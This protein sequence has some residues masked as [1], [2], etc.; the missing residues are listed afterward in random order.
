MNKNPEVFVA[1][2]DEQ[3]CVSA[4]THLSLFDNGGHKFLVTLAF[5]M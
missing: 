4:G 1:V 3:I 2:N 5:G